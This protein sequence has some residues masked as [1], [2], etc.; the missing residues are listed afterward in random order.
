MGLGAPVLTSREGA[1]PEV[2]GDAALFV[3]AYDPRDIARGLERLAA[4]DALCRDLSARGL[5]QAEAFG[6]D[7]YQERVSAMYRRVLGPDGR[8]GGYSRP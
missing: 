3:D 5:L 4:D 6:M 8:D 2:A 7:R 1:L